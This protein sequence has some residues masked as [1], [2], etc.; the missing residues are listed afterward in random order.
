[1]SFLRVDLFLCLRL[2][3]LCSSVV[4]FAG[5]DVWCRVGG[6]HNLHSTHSRRD[7]LAEGATLRWYL[8]SGEM[9]TTTV[10]KLN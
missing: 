5:F 10:D 2:C 1:M 6:A 3:L 4:F 9:M 7:P 8:Y